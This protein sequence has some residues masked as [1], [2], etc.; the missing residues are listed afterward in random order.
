MK[1]LYKRLEHESTA[2]AEIDLALAHIGSA[3]YDTGLEFLESV[4]EKRL[5]VACLGMIWIMRCPYF[6]GFWSHPGY[7]RLMTKM[8]LD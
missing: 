6:K 8:G 1:R 4:Y 5:S 3:N 2:S 7:K